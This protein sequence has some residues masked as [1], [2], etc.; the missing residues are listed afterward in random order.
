MAGHPR[1]VGLPAERTPVAVTADGAPQVL[2]HAE[3]EAVLKDPRF[4]AADLFA[5]SGITSGPVWEWWQR[6]MFSQ[7]PPGPHPAAV[8]W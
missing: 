6:V 2:R 8:G 3:V 1:P 5:M 4:V 7:D